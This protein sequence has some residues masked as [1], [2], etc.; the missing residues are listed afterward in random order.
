VSPQLPGVEAECEAAAMHGV[1]LFRWT[2]PGDVKVFA[3]G[4]LDQAI[5]WAAA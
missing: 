1:A 3:E 2:M 4:E 5:E